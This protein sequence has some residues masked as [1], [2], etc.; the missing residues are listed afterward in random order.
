MQFSLKSQE[1]F[2]QKQNKNILK[3]IWNHKRSQIA[4]AILWGEKPGGSTHSHFKLFHKATA[5]N[6]AW[7]WQKEKSRYIDQCN[8]I[9]SPV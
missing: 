1:H 7:N 4:K 3:F 6:T 2:S 5:I 9:E 8:R